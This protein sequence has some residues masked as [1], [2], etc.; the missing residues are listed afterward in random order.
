M[1]FNCACIMFLLKYFHVFCF[2]DFWSYCF[3]FPQEQIFYQPPKSLT[4]SIGMKL[5]LIPR[6]TFTMG[7]SE[8]EPGYQEDEKQ[9][10]VTITKDY[11]IGAFEVTQSQYEKVMGKKPSF[12][13]GEKLAE[14]QLEKGRANE[15][16]GSSNHPVERVT[17]ENA[18]EFC[19]RLSE[20]PEEK[21]AGRMYRLPTEAEW[22]YACRA[23]A[24]T[25]YSFGENAKSIGDY[26][27][28][29]GNSNNQ[30]HPVGL[31]KP[32]DWGLYDM[33]GNVWEW[34]SDNYANY[35]KGALTDPLGP[36]TG[37]AR[38]IR[39]GSWAYSA[40]NCRSANRGR[41]VPIRRYS[42]GGFRVVLGSC[43]IP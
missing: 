37:M 16:V 4:N 39:G 12:F 9:H 21:K 31:K 42:A 28:F 41:T 27:W 24:K 3:T 25:A 40:V 32:N 30:T 10:E 7:A 19:N 35:P 29:G 6:G 38:V 2:M 33:N 22:E 23:G 14:R 34:C 17:W 13:Q 26:A 15:A 1:Y 20:L 11:H 36:E 18:V 5:V 43:R 8:S